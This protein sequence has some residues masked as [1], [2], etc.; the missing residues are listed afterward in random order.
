MTQAMQNSL[1]TT[2]ACYYHLGQLNLALQDAT[3]ALRIDP[4]FIR[5]H[6]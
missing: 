2:A 4:N 6:M 1:V 3:E 5:G